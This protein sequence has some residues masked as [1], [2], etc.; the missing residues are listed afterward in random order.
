MR[1]LF[2]SPTSIGAGAEKQG[3]GGGKMTTPTAHNDGEDTTITTI[4]EQDHAKTPSPTTSAPPTPTSPRQTVT[5]AEETTPP[6]TTTMTT[7]PTTTTT[8]TSTAAATEEQEEPEQVA[9]ATP[10]PAPAAPSRVVHLRNITPEVTHEE[11]VSAVAEFGRVDKVVM[12]KTKRQA[13]VQMQ[14]VQAAMALVSHCAQC[15]IKIR[16]VCVRAGNC[17]F[18]PVFFSTVPFVPFPSA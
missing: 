7:D 13:M 9:A 4:T 6:T 1:F 14:D 8:T 16:C 15:P 10:T 2:S 11:L 18:F 12:M 17:T 5:A 3:N